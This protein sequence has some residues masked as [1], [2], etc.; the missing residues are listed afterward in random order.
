MPLQD[1]ETKARCLLVLFH[2]LPT[3]K[4][5][6]SCRC[7]RQD[8]RARPCSRSRSGIQELERELAVTKEYLQT[9]I[10]EQE[11]TNE[12]LKSANEELQSSNEELQST[13]EELETSKEE[14]QSTNEELTT[15]NDELQ[16]RMAE[17]S[18]RN[19]DLHNV[20]AGV[21]NAV[22]IVGMDLRIRRYTSAAEKLF[23]LVPGDVGR[24]IGFLDPFLGA[25]ALETE[26]VRR[27]PEPR[28]VE[29]E[30]LASNHRWY[31]LR[32]S[33]YKTLDHSIRGALVT[34]VDIDVRKRAAEMTRD[35]GAY[36]DRFLAAIGHP[37]LI[38]DRKL[39]VVWCNDPFLSTF[40]LT[41]EETVGSLLRASARGSS[42]IRDCASAGEGVRSDSVF[43][44]YELRVRLAGR[45]RAR[46]EGR[47]QPV[48]ASTDAPVALLVHRA[49][50]RVE[51]RGKPMTDRRSSRRCRRRSC[52]AS[53]RS[54]RPRSAACE[55]TVAASPIANA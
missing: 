49:C 12:E 40:Q 11:S 48:P 7:R 4:E 50:R 33:P 39:R 32:I 8:R 26:G 45:G 1:P 9:T 5:V 31:A 42:P 3:P 35:V 13:N 44:D 28:H 55:R 22:V 2:R 29:E 10:E 18:S 34:L 15:V 27:H 54:S 52:S 19:D 41:R 20:L 51:P 37:L 17:L 30:L 47:R 16:N 14:L 53:S 36:A 23:N 25:G 6:P 46:G 24:S 38:V 21:D 43:R